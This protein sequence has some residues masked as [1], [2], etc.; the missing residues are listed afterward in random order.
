M[1]EL[2]IAISII[3]IITAISVPIYKSSMRRTNITK[4]VNKLSTFKIELTDAYS[5]THAWPAAIN[6][7]TAGTTSSNSFFADATNF[8][9][10]FADNKAW[11]GYKLSSDYGSGWLFLVIIAEDDDSFNVHC[12]ALSGDCTLGSCN[13]LPNF[14]AACAETGLDASYGLE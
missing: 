10:Q 7:S 14:P 12:G 2:M 5:S 1:I 11:L 4:M 8:R 3:G 6:G 13:S 9:Y